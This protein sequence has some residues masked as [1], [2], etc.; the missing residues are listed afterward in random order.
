M[1]NVHS[2]SK[3][4]HET[5]QINHLGKMSPPLMV[6]THIYGVSNEIDGKTFI[7]FWEAQP[8]SA[9]SLKICTPTLQLLHNTEQRSLV[10]YCNHVQFSSICN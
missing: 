10:F 7:Q 1:G 9:I 5:T 4:R 6:S 2:Y 8:I 3:P